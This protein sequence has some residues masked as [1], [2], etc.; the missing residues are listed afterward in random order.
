MSRNPSFHVENFGATRQEPT[1]VHLRPMTTGEKAEWDRMSCEF[2]GGTYGCHQLDEDGDPCII[3]QLEVYK[4][5]S[6]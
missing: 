6:V 1:N 4:S 5:E 2:C 3:G